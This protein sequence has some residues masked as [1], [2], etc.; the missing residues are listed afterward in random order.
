MAEAR[1]IVARTSDIDAPSLEDFLADLARLD[2]HAFVESKIPGTFARVRRMLLPHAR[3]LTLISFDGD[4][5]G[6]ATA[7]GFSSGCLMKHRPSARALETLRALY[8]FRVLLLDSWY[9]SKAT[10]AAAHAL[11]L[12]VVAWDVSKDQRETLS[13][14]GI[15]GIICNEPVL[16]QS[17][18]ARPRGRVDADDAASA[19]EAGGQ[20]A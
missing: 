9:V 12:S 18:G 16:V 11:G 4:E 5:I 15:D 6:A 7:L 8:G 20:R 2:L 14:M 19:P 3:R 17:E 13:A 10:V 1:A